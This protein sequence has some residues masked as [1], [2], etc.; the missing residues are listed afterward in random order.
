MKSAAQ[1]L[2]EEIQ[3]RKIRAR[4]IRPT[5]R[6]NMRLFDLLHWKDKRASK[7]RERIP[8]ACVLTAQNL[9][10]VQKRPPKRKLSGAEVKKGNNSS[11]QGKVEDTS[12]F[13]G[14]CLLRAKD[15][16]LFADWL[17]KKRNAYVTQTIQNEI[18]KIMSTIILRDIIISKVK[19]GIWYAIM[20]DECVDTNNKEQ[21]VICL[22]LVGD[23]LEVSEN[24]IGFYEIENIKAETIFNTIMDSL[25]R[26]NIGIQNCRGVS[27]D[28]AANMSGLKTGVVKRLNDKAEGLAPFSHCYGHSLSLA[29]EDVFKKKENPT[30][31]DCLDFVHEISKLIK[32]SPK[33]DALLSKLKAELSDVAGIPGIRILCPTRW[34][35]KGS[36]CK[37]ISKNYA[38]L[39]QLWNI[40]LEDNIDSETRLRIVGI[41]A[42]MKKFDFF[43]ALHLSCR[44]FMITDNLS[45]TLQQTRVSA[46][47]VRDIA[48]L[49]VKILM[50][51]RNEEWFNLWWQK[52]QKH[53]YDFPDLEEPKLPRKSKM[54]ARY[55]DFLIED[56]YEGYS[57]TYHHVETAIQYYRA[58]YYNVID[59]SVDTIKYRFDQAG[60]K[61]LKKLEKLLLSEDVTDTIAWIKKTY[62]DIDTDLLN[63]Q[64]GLYRIMFDEIPRYVSDVVSHL[65]QFSSSQL[66]FISKVV[67]LLKLILVT[68]ATNAVSERAFSTMRRL[69][70]FLR[71]TK[72]QQRL[73]NLAMLHIYSNCANQLDPEK[74]TT[75]FCRYHPYRSNLF[76]F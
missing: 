53:A 64:L 55:E 35:V 56:W 45:K 36:S 57:S 20:A 28:G 65:T 13:Y 15:D 5:T 30:L 9:L 60:Q 66:S 37:S 50:D 44:I 47:E 18:L 54:P 49:T 67:K 42:T 29:V 26:C 1:L 34:T 68:P 63:V 39:L 71:T 58:T 14:L 43:F 52:I 3:M 75:E 16:P 21:L 51:M 70:T 69:K 46:S 24:F 31:S 11:I 4:K 8:A 40:C 32:K 12:N 38:L 61:Q 17:E 74:V 7:R 2:D 25:L 22:R 48:I 19:D 73:N 62:S 27:F 6:V 72:K 59:S 10:I 33:R 41:Q 76:E 23:K